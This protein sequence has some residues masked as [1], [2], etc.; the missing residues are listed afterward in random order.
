MQITSPE[1]GKAKIEIF[2]V[3]GQKLQ[4]RTVWVQKSENNIVPFTVAQHGAIFY[5]VQIGKYIVNGK[6]IGPN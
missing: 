3:T 5:R 1:E 4:E 6:V 2:T